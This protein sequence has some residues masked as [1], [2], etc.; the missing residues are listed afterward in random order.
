MKIY[1]LIILCLFLINR[2]YAGLKDALDEGDY[3]FNWLF[4]SICIILAII[5]QS[6]TL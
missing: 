3:N 6:I 2:L 4:P 1:V 5:F